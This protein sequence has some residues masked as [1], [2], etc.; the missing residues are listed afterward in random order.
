[1][2]AQSHRDERKNTLKIICTA[3][4][5]EYERT[6]DTIVHKNDRVLE[7]A[8]QLK[9]TTKKLLQAAAFGKVIGVDIP[10]KVPKSLEGSKSMYRTSDGFSFI[11]TLSLSDA[12]F[13]FHEI[14]DMLGLHELWNV[15]KDF[16]VI[17]LDTNTAVGNDLLLDTMAVLNQLQMLYEHSLHT[18]VVKSRTL[19][20]HAMQIFSAKQ[21]LKEKQNSTK[22]EK[23]ILTKSFGTCTIPV[24]GVEQYREMIPLVI[25]PGD[26]VLEI[27]CHSGTSAEL[28]EKQSG[29]TG[30][31]IGVDIGPKIIELAR[32]SH[33]AVKFEVADA[34]DTVSLQSL[35]SEFHVIFVDVGGLS[36]QNGLLEALA[37]VR[38]LKYA[39]NPSLRTVV[40][41]SRCMKDHSDQLLVANQHLFSAGNPRGK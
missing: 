17:Y 13:E 11:K 35:C 31:V 38:Q 39:Y 29:P 33:P 12:N 26:N 15:G 32:K 40:I 19:T 2:K 8:C 25:K 36:G 7:I 22:K 18:I 28:M 14:Q 1:M 4:L 9:V 3:S 20:E 41:K 6:I 10:R 16:S 21:I 24:I 23:A 37:L 27:G 5:S 30:N 34:W